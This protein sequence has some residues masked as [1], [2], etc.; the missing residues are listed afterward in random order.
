MLLTLLR[1]LTLG[2]FTLIC[3]YA[4]LSSYA[5]A[6]NLKTEVQVNICE[7]ADVIQT[8]LGLENW[9]SKPTQETYYIENKDLSLFKKNWV[10]KASINSAK[11]DVDIILKK[12]SPT[13]FSKALKKCEYDLHGDSKKLA[14]K[15]INTISLNEFKHK[16][17]KADYIGLLNDEQKDW[18]QKENLSIPNDV[19]L[20][21][22]FEDYAFVNNN[23]LEISITK[24]EQGTSFIE[25]SSRSSEKKELALQK[26]ILEFLKKH[27]VALCVDQRAQLTREKLE[28]Y[29]NNN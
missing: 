29:F 11:N 8:K 10:F 16:I 2:S 24:N 14:C 28:S 17:H 5:L 7:H 4:L 1:S 9:K 27:Q 20:T 18:L 3:S 15:M 19:V 23:E 22:A 6:G 26:K 25:A 21:T 12:N 13:A